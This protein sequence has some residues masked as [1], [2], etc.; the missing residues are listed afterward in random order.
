METLDAHGNKITK[1]PPVTDGCRADSLMA[2]SLK[3]V[4]SPLPC[5]ISY[6]RDLEKYVKATH[7]NSLQWLQQIKVSHTKI[8]WKLGK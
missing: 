6:S 3:K 1:V 2:T 8:V 7:L 4:L 5:C